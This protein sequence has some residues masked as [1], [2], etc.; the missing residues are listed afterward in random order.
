V[1]LPPTNR[2]KASGALALLAFLACLIPS[3]ATAALP[4]NR[5]WELV[6]PVEKNGGSIPAAGQIA[7]GGVLQA[8]AGGGSITYGSATSF[9]GG[10]GAPEGSQYLATRTTS[11]WTTQNISPSLFSGTYGSGALGVP[12]QLFSG[13]LSGALLLSGRHC[14]SEEGNCPVANPP[15]PGT[16][17]PAGYQDYYLRNGS[18][19]FEALLGTADVANTDLS[20]A[21][22]DLSFVGAT[23]DLAHVVLSSCAA[24][25]SGA[26][27]VPLGEDCDPAKQ[28]LYE[29]SASSGL[30]LLNAA[31][32]ATLAAQASAISSD[33][34]RVY[35]SEGGNLYLREG[36]QLKQADTA[37]G[38]GGS[39][40]T[41][42]TNGA[43]AYFTKEAHLW[44]YEAAAGTA[45]DL[46]PSGGVV[47]VLGASADGSFIYYLAG[48]G[49]HLLHGASDTVIAVAPNPLTE[50][51]AEPSDYPPPTG[52]ARTSADGTHLAFL[53]KAPL[54]GYDNTDQKTGLPDTEVFLY[55]SSG[56]G[57][58]RCVSCR[59]NG[60]A[61][62]G[63]SSIPGAIAN[64]E[65][66]GATEAYKPR[67]LSADGSRVF[68]DSRDAVFG[69][70]T[71]NDAD[72][73]QWEAQGPGCTKA[74]GCVALISSGRSEGGASFADASANGNDVFFLTDGSLVGTDPGSVDLYDARAGGGFPEPLVPIPCF[75]DSCQNLPPEPVDP[76]LTT[77]VSGPGNPKVKYR[78][79]K[80]HVAPKGCSGKKCKGGKGKGKGKKHGAQGHGAKK[81]RGR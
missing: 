53:S 73:Y 45:T 3:A 1:K 34:S 27:E 56:A 41:A 78:K 67:A 20:P 55:S 47:G 64:G 21:Q 59:P 5:G 80:R 75:G 42:S 38:G 4:D 32:G 35:L 46:T 10:Q 61:P 29:W 66:V 6:S 40:Q 43:I 39:F 49:L 54:T 68:F 31:P 16:D 69:P 74:T 2:Y 11:G 71:N 58:L 8:A 52:T 77:L 23:P 81:G 72:V 65:Q 44:R 9:A 17:A 33:G 28:N 26:T 36:A 50:A 79:Y 13:D 60:T 25:T 76:A 14:R 12:Y 37:A 22:F 57:Q 63:P 15:L 70:D 51:T 18:G 62:A 30:T 24:L 19:G 48:D 7:G